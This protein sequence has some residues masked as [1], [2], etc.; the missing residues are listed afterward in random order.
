MANP[1][2]AAGMIA[3]TT[4]IHNAGPLIDL[5][6]ANTHHTPNPVM[7]NVPI[8]LPRRPIEPFDQI[9]TF[10]RTLLT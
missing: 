1:A 3:T 8:A 10:E 2:S 5:R 6:A 9:P 7:I 4:S